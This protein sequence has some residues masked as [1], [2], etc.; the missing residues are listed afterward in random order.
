MFNEGI[1]MLVSNGR[2]VVLAVN[3][4]LLMPSLL[5]WTE[6]LFSVCLRGPILH[7]F[8]HLPVASVIIRS[9]VVVIPSMWAPA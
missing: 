9:G 3:H 8:Y 1:V 7:A 4:L 5:C 6:L 2:W